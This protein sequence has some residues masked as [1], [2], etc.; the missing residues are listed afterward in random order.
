MCLS[1]HFHVLFFQ[2]ELNLIRAVQT[3][4]KGFIL[5]FGSVSGRCAILNGSCF[6]SVYIRVYPAA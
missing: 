3:N 6:V 4:I 1:A 5:F 2:H